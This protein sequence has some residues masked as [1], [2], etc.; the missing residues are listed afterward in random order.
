MPP[1]ARRIRML[2]V[3]VVATYTVSSRLSAQSPLPADLRARIDS[4]ARAALKSSGAPS[5]SLAVVKDGQVAYAQAYGQARLS[6]ALA[7]APAMR[8]SIGS[9]S[10]QITATAVLLLAE[11]D[12]LSLDDKVSRWFPDAY[13]R[14][15][16][17]AFAS[18]S[19]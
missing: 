10:K 13:A 8:Y 9:V 18:C 6:P 12:K 2:L 7:A 1:I 3:A 16:S 17:D 11:Q 19:R 5:I 15:R 14:E 4:V